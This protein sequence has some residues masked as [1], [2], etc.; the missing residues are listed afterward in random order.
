[1]KRPRHKC[2]GIAPA[3]G[4]SFTVLNSAFRLNRSASEVEMQALFTTLFLV[5][6]VLLIIVVLLQ[7]GRGGGIA[8]AFGGVGHTAFGTRTGDVFT[9][10]TIVLV[11]VFLVLAV[12]SDKAFKPKMEPLPKPRFSATPQ[13]PG[14][15]VLV[16]IDGDSAQIKIYFTLNGQD[17]TDRD[18]LHE[19][20]TP[21]RVQP[22]STLRVRAYG[23]GSLRSELA[24]YV[25]PGE[26]A[27][28]SSAPAVEATTTSAPASRPVTTS[29]PSAAP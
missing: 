15:P 28:T 23:Q 18:T 6:C 26:A 2:S 16:R 13:G 21:I 3:G 5:T 12:V 7:R 19:P 24:E 9:W 20:R 25:A 29:A 14:K 8:G 17:P 10:V 4:V 27:T 1:M 22:G 11:A